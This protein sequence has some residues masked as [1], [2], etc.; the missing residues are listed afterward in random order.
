MNPEREENLYTPPFCGEAEVIIWTSLLDF[1]PPPSPESPVSDD[2]G[3]LVSSH[4]LWMP[5]KGFGMP[6][7][8]VTTGDFA[9]YIGAHIFTMHR[10]RKV[11]HIHRALAPDGAMFNQEEAIASLEKRIGEHRSLEPILDILAEGGEQLYPKLI[12]Q[13]LKSVNYPLNETCFLSNVRKF[14]IPFWNQ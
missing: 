4:V 10:D 1:I 13:L 14:G 11:L 9:G 7:G 3:K 6:V 5:V 12:A 2:K 8:L